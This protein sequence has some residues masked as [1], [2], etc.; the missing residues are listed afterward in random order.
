MPGHLAAG[1]P[2]HL[3]ALFAPD[4]ALAGL[5]EYELRVT[6]A[7]TGL[8]GTP[9]KAPVAAPFTTAPAAPTPHFTIGGTVS[10]LQGSGLVLQNGGADPLTVTANGA[11]TFATGLAHGAAYNVTSS[12]EPTNPVQV[13]SVTRGK[14]TVLD[15]NVTTVAVACTGVPPTT[16]V[17]KSVS[18]GVIPQ[19]RRDC[20]WRRLLLGAQLRR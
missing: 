17:F 6:Q 20:E 5:T 16:P 13:C 19:L 15:D 10:G 1:D 8:D 9:L 11:F 18:A 7:V 14:G 3:T 12:R 4:S 2:L